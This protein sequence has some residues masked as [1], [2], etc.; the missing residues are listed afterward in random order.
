MGA[1]ILR[2]LW[3]MI[4]TLGGVILFVFFLFKWF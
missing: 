4:P 3:Q 1:Y 2:R